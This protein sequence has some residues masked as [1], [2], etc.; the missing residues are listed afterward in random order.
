MR[1]TALI[2]MQIEPS[3]LGVICDSTISTASPSEP[4]TVVLLSE[5]FYEYSSFLTF[6]IHHTMS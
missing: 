6:N 3:C 5:I 4:Y 2:G 1:L